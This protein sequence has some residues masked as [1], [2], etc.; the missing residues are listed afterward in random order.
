MKTDK[1]VYKIFSANPR[2]FFEITG[3]PWAPTTYGGEA[4]GCVPG[5][6]RP[7]LSGVW[8]KGD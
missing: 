3:R 5:L 2:W 6:A 4:V 1:Q 7:T 8:Q